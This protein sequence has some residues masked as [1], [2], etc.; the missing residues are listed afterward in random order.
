MEEGP[1]ETEVQRREGGG[2]AGEGRGGEPEEVEGDVHVSGGDQEV[3][4]LDGCQK[5]RG[6]RPHHPRGQGLKKESALFLP[7]AL[8]LLP[9]S[10]YPS[11]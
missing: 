5:G 9:S 10:S 11:F 7:T 2:R 1:E 8:V 4:S 6:E 3:A